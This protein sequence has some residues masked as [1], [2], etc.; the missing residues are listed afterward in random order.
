MDGWMNGWMDGRVDGVGHVHDMTRAGGG[1][2]AMWIELGRP[3]LSIMR[4]T[5]ARRHN[6][7]A[8]SSCAFCYLAAGERSLVH[9]KPRLD[10][11]Q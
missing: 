4:H 9:G 11:T 3:G 6:S 7:G 2:G 8:R 10:E 1:Q 5:Q